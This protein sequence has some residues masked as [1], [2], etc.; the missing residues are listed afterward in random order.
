MS[1]GRN[2]AMNK[3][4]KGRPTNHSR[5][6]LENKWRKAWDAYVDGAS[7]AELC[8]IVSRERQ[9]VM[10]KISREGWPKLKEQYLAGED[11][12]LPWDRIVIEESTKKESKGKPVTREQVKLASQPLEKR[13]KIVKAFAL[14][15][16]GMAY[17]QIAEQVEVSV[18][19]I[20]YWIF[21]QKWRMCRD[22]AVKGEHI[23]P[24]EG[25]HIPFDIQ[26]ATEGIRTMAEAFKER[27]G[28]VLFKALDT[29]E[30]WDGVDL[31]DRINDVKK[32]GESAE[33]VL[34]E[35]KPEVAQQFNITAPIESVQ[36]QPDF[37]V[38][39]D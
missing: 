17:Q 36:V 7:T 28:K 4:N 11:I 6:I 32:L 2:T 30:E 38:S 25:E 19:T 3:K 14:Y 15:C 21:S 18:S 27:Y 22:K 10:N 16:S 39:L 33:K 13:A 23:T 29:V 37:D 5:R 24:W 1:S 34:I 31:M 35:K 8:R 12:T 9:T 26:A 20:N